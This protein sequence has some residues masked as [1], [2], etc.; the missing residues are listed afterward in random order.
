MNTILL[1]ILL[2]ISDIIE[3]TYDLGDATRRY[4]LP[5]LVYVYVRALMAYE[6]VTTMEWT[7]PPYKLSHSPLSWA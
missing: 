1:S 4:V 3:L 2:F 5:A 7:V 6:S